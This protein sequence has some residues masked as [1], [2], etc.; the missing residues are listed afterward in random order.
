MELFL[1]RVKTLFKYRHR[2]AMHDQFEKLGI[3]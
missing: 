3:M 2:V 1:F